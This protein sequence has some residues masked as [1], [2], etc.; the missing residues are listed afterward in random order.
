M[1]SLPSMGTSPGCIMVL[2]A[3]RRL[4]ARLTATMEV[5]SGQHAAADGP[6]SAALPLSQA[7]AP[8]VKGF[9]GGHGPGDQARH[10]DPAKLFDNVGEMKL[11]PLSLN[12]AVEQGAKLQGGRGGI[13]SALGMVESNDFFMS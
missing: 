2:S 1:V 4:A 5:G 13:Y 9:V 10:G 7:Y 12:S 3:Q 6:S 8:V 11:R